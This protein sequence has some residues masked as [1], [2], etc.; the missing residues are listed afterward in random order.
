MYFVVFFS[1]IIIKLRGN[2][3]RGKIFAPAEKKFLILLVLY[4]LSGVYAMIYSVIVMTN[5]DELSTELT[6]YFQCEAT[7][8]SPGKCSRDAF[9]LWANSYSILSGILNLL[10]AMIPP[11]FIISF[12]FNWQ[13]CCFKNI[14][15]G[16]ESKTLELNE[17][18]S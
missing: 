17:G 18:Q 10:F 14:K 4:L 12:L 13:T 1:I 2:E 16:K 7:G 9:Q 8:Y 3:I 15:R 6:N 5:A 11:A